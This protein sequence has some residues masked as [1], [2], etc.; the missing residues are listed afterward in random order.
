MFLKMLIQLLIY[1][2]ITIV[3]QLINRNNYALLITHSLHTVNGDPGGG[4]RE[5]DEGLS[6]RGRRSGEHH[7]GICRGRE[8]SHAVH[9][10]YIVL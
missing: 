7:E 8:Y 2:F 9:I 6:G 3:D 4:E 5:A 1:E 10:P